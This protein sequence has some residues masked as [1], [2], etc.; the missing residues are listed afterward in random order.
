MIRN[1][2]PRG[3]SAL[4]ASISILASFAALVAGGSFAAAGA[5]AAGSSAKPASRAAAATDSVPLPRLRPDDPW[6]PGGV[7]TANA[8]RRTLEAKGK[9]GPVLLHVGFGVLY[10]GGHIPGS[11]FAG[12]GSKLEGVNAIN[13]ALRDVPRERTV[14]IY[15][16][17]CPWGDC[18]NLRPAYRAAEKL[19]FKDVRVLY[20][21]RSLKQDWIDK[22]YGV[23][24]TLK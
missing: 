1:E 4:R 18:P 19:G 14:I 9:A 13:L 17:C 8:L 11:E 7:L 12:P 24:Q 6:K 2:I 23:E 20:L 5:G 16:G 21:P 22:G 3:R 10:R 15:C